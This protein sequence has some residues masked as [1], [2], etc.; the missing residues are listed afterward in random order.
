[1]LRGHNNSHKMFCHQRDRRKSQG[2]SRI[3]MERRDGAPDGILPPSALSNP[4]TDRPP[5]RLTIH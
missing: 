2:M 4:P 5:I 1:M 3:R